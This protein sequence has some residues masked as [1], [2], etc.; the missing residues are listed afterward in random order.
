[1]SPADLH[2]DPVSAAERMAQV[3]AGVRRDG[4]VQREDPLRRSDGSVFEAEQTISII[5]PEQGADGPLVNVIR[6]VSERKEREEEL[7]ASETRFRQ[8]AEHIKDVFWVAE[9]GRDRIEYVSPAFRDVWGRD[10]AELYE[11]P[12]MWAESILPSDRERITAS[13]D[14]QPE[15]GWEEEYRIVRP[16]GEVRWIW[17]R[18]FPVRGPEGEVERIIGVAEDVT[19][20]KAME[21]R[22]GVLSQE[23]TDLIFVVDAR[24]VVQS[25]SASTERFGGYPLDEFVGSDALEIVHEDD[26]DSLRRM[27]QDIV[28]HPGAVARAEHRMVTREGEVRHVESVGRNRLDH[29]AIQ[30][31]I[32]TA[33]DITERIQLE[34]RLRQSQKMEAIGR[35]AG[36]IAHDFNNL[37]TVI[38]SQTD[39]ILMDL[40][41]DGTL[42]AELE[43]IQTAADRAA[44]LTSQLLA[45]SRDQVLRPRT[46]DLSVVV[47]GMGRLLERIIGEDVRV[48]YDLEQELP[49]VRIDPAQL[50]QVILNLAVNARDAMP[51]GGRLELSTSS[52]QVSE[53]VADEAPGLD[54]GPRV[55]LAVSDT[56]VGMSEEV[57]ARI[58]EP[59]FTTK[60]TGKG[61]GLGLAMA[62]GFVKQSGGTIHVRSEPGDGATFLLRF[63]VAEGEAEDVRSGAGARLGDVDVRGRVLVVEDDPDVRRVTARILERAGIEVDAVED[64]ETG[65]A[66]LEDDGAYALLLTDLVLPGMSGRALVDWALRERPDLRVVVMS[67]YDKE[68]PGHR[69]DLP[70]EIAFIQKP[71]TPEALV[72]A[73]RRALDEGPRKG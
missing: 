4:R 23:I 50:E 63:P 59:F 43:A 36:G 37:L 18:A 52:E 30:G 29:P 55:V 45:F 5:D 16:D 47:Q 71:F 31:V 12:E 58:F 3:L 67:G 27:L 33:R 46:V 11:T 32:V 20:R 6:D 62:Y 8:I 25:A 13:V 64:A 17:D 24:G 15:G 72:R 60:K 7:R 10:P 54:P 44:Q 22:F 9:P 41:D 49:P 39:L 73:V 57:Q 40:A 21:E 1:M 51:E 42:G 38:R 34:E 70:S 65:R 26:R 53:E 69:G 61:T 19:E 68:S 28:A 2:V 56:G 14:R 48:V 35:L 66:E